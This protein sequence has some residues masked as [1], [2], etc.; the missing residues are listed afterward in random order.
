MMKLQH[1]GQGGKANA[2]E[3]LRAL[4]IQ[5]VA[6]NY[7]QSKLS[8]KTVVDLFRREGDKKRHKCVLERSKPV[9][10]QS[11]AL[12]C[13]RWFRSRGGLSVHCCIGLAKQVILEFLA[14]P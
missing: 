4:L 1:L 2:E 6:V 8:A 5:Q 14:S 13:S 3:I 12:Q 7:P 11:G 10:E 9:S